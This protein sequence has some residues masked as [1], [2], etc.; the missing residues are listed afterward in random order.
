M[1]PANAQHT[2]AVARQDE[3]LSDQQVDHGKAD[4]DADSAIHDAIAVSHYQSVARGVGFASYFHC[5]MAGPSLMGSLANWNES[6]TI[7]V[8]SV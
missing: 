7:Q 5:V 6:N 8:V 1:S 2:D 3:A 4:R